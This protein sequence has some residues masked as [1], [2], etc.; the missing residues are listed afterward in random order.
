MHKTTYIV[1]LVVTLSLLGYTAFYTFT[2]PTTPLVV[3]PV[4]AT[5]T[6]P[7]IEET[8][9]QNIL[10]TKT[11]KRITVNETNPSGES[12]STITLIP[13][14]FENNSEIVLEK[15]K[16]T[17]FFL[18]DLDR[19]GYDELA[20]IT[21]SAGSGSY[22]DITLFTTSKD[23]TLA[24]LD[25]PTL[26]EDLTKKGAL[27][28]GYQGHDNFKKVDDG[29]LVREFPTYN[30]SDTNNLPTGPVKKVFYTLTMA[31]SGAYT[32]NLVSEVKVGSSTVVTTASTTAPKS[33]TGSTAP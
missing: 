2:K 5:T 7:A 22:G 27:F 9:P 21:T 17:N 31:T 1:L 26:D 23:K 3:A 28:D 30:A 14:G 15:N 13:S 11:G 16:L 4:V 12:L 24:L 10:T 6:P 20:V 32:V 18:I 33:S 29:L 8:P 19:D 25:V